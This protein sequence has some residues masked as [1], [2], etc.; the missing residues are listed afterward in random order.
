MPNVRQ[1]TKI[2]VDGGDAEETLRIRNLLGYVVGQRA[3]PTYV[4]KN[5]EVQQIIGCGRKFTREGQN[6]EYRKIV[7]RISPLVGSAGVSIEVF[8]DFNT[9]AEQMLSQG[10]EMFG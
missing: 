4:A 3:N 8:A 9:K 5:P 6:D 2:L 10:G 7:R 1:T